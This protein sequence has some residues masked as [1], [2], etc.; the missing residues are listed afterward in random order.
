MLAH[1]PAWRTVIAQ[2]VNASCRCTV[3]YS[4]ADLYITKHLDAFI[5]RNSF[6][7]IKLLRIY[8]QGTVQKKFAT[9]DDIL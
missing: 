8:F 7:K 1:A 6:R 9:I 4:A 5:A 2:C 3:C